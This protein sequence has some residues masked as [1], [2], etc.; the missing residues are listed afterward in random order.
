MDRNSSSSFNNIHFRIYRWSSKS[1]EV[2]RMNLINE[3]RL[4]DISGGSTQITGTIFNA[5]VNLIE[6]LADAGRSLGSGIRRLSE[7][8]VCPLK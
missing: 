4:N 2:W 5:I 8:N 3:E 7:G 6:L 1:K